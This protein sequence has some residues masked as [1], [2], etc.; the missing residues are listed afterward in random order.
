VV[1]IVVSEVVMVSLSF[2]IEVTVVVL[3][4][5][6]GEPADATSPWLTSPTDVLLLRAASP[7]GCDSSRRACT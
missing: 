4:S 1:V 5:T 7:P 6:L 3:A 2:V